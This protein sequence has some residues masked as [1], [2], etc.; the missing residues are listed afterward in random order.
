MEQHG[1][2]SSCLI[3]LILS[4]KTRRPIFRLSGPVHLGLNALV[5]SKVNSLSEF[6]LVCGPFGMYGPS[7][8]LQ[9]KN[10]NDRIGLR[11]C[12]RPLLEC[13]APS[14]FLVTLRSKAFSECRFS[15]APGSTVFAI[16]WFASKPGRNLKL[17][18]VVVVGLRMW[19]SRQRFPSLAHVPGV[20][21]RSS[22]CEHLWF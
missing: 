13:A 20:I 17:R 15:G 3:C 19:E 2:R 6:R 16:S 10:E 22:G 14:S 5:D 12:I 21:C 11:E 9:A 18:S 8:F 7:P 4:V 1:A